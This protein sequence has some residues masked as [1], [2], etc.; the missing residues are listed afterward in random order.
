[1][2]GVEELSQLQ[3]ALAKAKIDLLLAR[4]WSVDTTNLAG[5]ELWQREIDG[6]TYLVEIE[7][8]LS[9]E[10]I[11]DYQACTCDDEEPKPCPVHRIE[12]TP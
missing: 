12:D 5:C 7:T 4:G 11:I 3:D 2:S 10:M 8:A 6:R 9:I 1:M